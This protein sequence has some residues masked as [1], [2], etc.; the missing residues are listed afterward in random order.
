VPSLDE[1]AALNQPQ[2]PPAVNQDG[3]L[4]LS[5]ELHK[6]YQKAKQ[7]LQDAEYE[8][9][10]LNYRVQA[11][12]AISSI[13][14]QLVKLQSDLHTLEEVKKIEAALGTTLKKFPEVQADFF[15]ELGKALR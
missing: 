5:D 12:N 14:A 8:E 1:I 4:D 11:L 3:P 9:A 7:M 2:K 15:D 10:P 6:Q 13:I